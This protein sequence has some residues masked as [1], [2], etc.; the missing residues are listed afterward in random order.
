VPGYGH[1]G[2]TAADVALGFDREGLGA[3]VNSAR[4]IIYAYRDTGLPFAEAAA[5]AT[6]EMRAAL[7]AALTPPGR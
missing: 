1:Q 5:Q 7:N 6:Q 4:G 3:L 2:G